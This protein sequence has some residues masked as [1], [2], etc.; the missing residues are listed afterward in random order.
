M[1]LTLLRDA[2]DRR[3]SV[4]IGYVDAEGG[5]SHRIIEPVAISGG[6]V[7]AYDRL[8]GAMRTFALHRISRV[9]PVEDDGTEDPAIAV[10]D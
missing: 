10:D 9:R 7:V 1:S 8:R 4:W 5:T 2:A 6:A 3:G